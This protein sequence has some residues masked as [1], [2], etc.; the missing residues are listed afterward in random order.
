LPRIPARARTS[1][2]RGPANI[3]SRPEDRARLRGVTG[4]FEGFC[5]PGEANSASWFLAHSRSL[6]DALRSVAS[7]RSRARWAGFSARRCPLRKLVFTGII[8]RMGVSETLPDHCQA[9]PGLGTGRPRAGLG[10]PQDPSTKSAIR[11]GASRGHLP[12]CPRT[13]GS[14]ENLMFAFE[15]PG[16]TLHCMGCIREPER[17]RAG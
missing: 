1:L 11:S 17:F 12:A 4:V 8:P 14:L 16:A 3:V 7:L 9:A 13:S 5:G 15:L 2:P 6:R 10:D